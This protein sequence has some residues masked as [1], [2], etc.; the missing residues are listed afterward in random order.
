MKLSIKIIS[1]HRGGY[2]GICPSLPGC[3]GCGKTG[4]EARQ[5]LNEAIRGYMA[6]MNNFVPEFQLFESANIGEGMI[7]S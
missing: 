7:A 2:T 4:V 1:N 5:A 6:A 3:V